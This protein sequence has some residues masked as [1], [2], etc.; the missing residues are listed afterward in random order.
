MKKLSKNL[1]PIYN[2]ELKAG[3]RVLR[4]DEPAGTKC[5]LAVIF[6]YPLHFEQISNELTLSSS[7]RRWENKDPH[8]PL[9]EGVVCEET[10]HV[11]AGPLDSRK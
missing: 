1:I 2:L 6:E 7:V 8:Y 4:I 9:E 11:V 3:N 5:P 10:G